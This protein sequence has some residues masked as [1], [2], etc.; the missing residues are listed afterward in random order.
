MLRTLFALADTVFDVPTKVIDAAL[1]WSAF[2]EALRH[3]SQGPYPHERTEGEAQGYMWDDRC[4][5]YR[6]DDSS[7]A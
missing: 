2:G 3:E 6:R 4:G 1:D 5:W 7:G